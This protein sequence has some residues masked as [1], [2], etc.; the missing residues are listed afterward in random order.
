M[1]EIARPPAVGQISLQS[2]V[3]KRAESRLCRWLQP[4]RSREICG[5]ARLRLTGC[6]WCVFCVR[7]GLRSRFAALAPPPKTAR[8][9]SARFCR[10]GAPTRPSRQKS[11]VRDQRMRPDQG[12]PAIAAL[13]SGGVASEDRPGAGSTMPLR[14]HG[15]ITKVADWPHS[16]GIVGPVG[17]INPSISNCTLKRRI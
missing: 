1:A 13:L 15:Q 17:S 16:K 3:W 7:D 14:L 8:P 2:A 6:R 5:R 10:K 11:A 9:V 4:S 12:R